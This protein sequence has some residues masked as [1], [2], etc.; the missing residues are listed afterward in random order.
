MIGRMVLFGASGDLTSRLLMPAVAAY[1]HL[2]LDMLNSHP[3]LF[4]RGDEAEQAWRIIDPVMK[5]WSAGDV[6]MEEY[7]AGQPPPG[8]PS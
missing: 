3:M 6:P 2:I 7:A 5:A 4:M 1:A 8:P